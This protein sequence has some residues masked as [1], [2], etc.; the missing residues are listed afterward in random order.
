M[1][2]RVW[3][4][5]KLADVQ[6]PRSETSRYTAQKSRPTLRL[7]AVSRQDLGP[8][9]TRHVGLHAPTPARK[10]AGTG[11]RRFGCVSV[12][13]MIHTLPDHPTATIH[14][15]QRSRQSQALTHSKLTCLL[16]PSQHALA[17]KRHLF[18]SAATET[19]PSR[20]PKSR[21]TRAKYDIPSPIRALSL[22][23]QTTG[24]TGGT[25]PVSYRDDPIIT[26]TM[27]CAPHV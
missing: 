8:P 23:D 12:V 4:Y 11:E 6:N 18:V 7:S 24:G 19:R 26:I 22:P 25:R 10:Y 16:S 9:S 13:H 20:T 2:P 14:L 17:S 21:L 1:W 15:Y 5:S 27:K 3:H